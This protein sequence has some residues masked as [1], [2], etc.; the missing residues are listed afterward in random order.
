M[1]SCFPPTVTVTLSG[2]LSKWRSVPSS[3]LITQLLPETWTTV[4]RSIL[5]DFVG[6][7]S[8]AVSV[9]VCT[10]ADAER[11]KTIQSVP[12]AN[13]PRKMVLDILVDFILFLL[14]CGVLALEN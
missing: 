14:F 10:C 11:E 7:P 4:P 6:A 1:L 12:P 3:A 5:I 13:R 2:T 8:G 9:L